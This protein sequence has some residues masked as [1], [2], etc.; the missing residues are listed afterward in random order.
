[1]SK[2]LI[3][4]GQRLSG[5]IKIHGAKNA[6]LPIIAAT[7]LNSGKCIIHDCPRL[8]DVYFSLEILKYIG[9]IVEWQDDSVF[10]DSTSIS[11]CHVPEKLMREMRSSVI[12]LGAILARCGK[13]VISYPGGCDSSLCRGCS[14]SKRGGHNLVRLFVIL[15]SVNLF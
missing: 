10:I 8:K 14:T 12:F 5:T 2:L 7:L 13:A 9:C 6:V 3:E 4:G 1:M 11:N 15:Q